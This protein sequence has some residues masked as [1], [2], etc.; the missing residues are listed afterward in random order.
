ML[1]LVV[2]LCTLAASAGRAVTDG[3]G[4]W[5]GG[6]DHPADQRADQRAD[7]PADQRADHRN[8]DGAAAGRDAERGATAV[9]YALMAGVIVI[10][11]IASVSMFT[12]SVGNMFTKYSSTIP[13]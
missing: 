6:P 7:H 5:R 10:A 8:D 12:G 4:R 11:I 1:R 9:E 3:F 2:I 13:V